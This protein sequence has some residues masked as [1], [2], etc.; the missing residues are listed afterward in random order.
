[1]KGPETRWS[2]GPPAATPDGPYYKESPLRPI[3][4]LAILAVLSVAALPAGALAGK[5][6]YGFDDNERDRLGWAIVSGDNTSMSDMSDL[7]SMGKLKSEFGRE[8]LYIRLGSDRYVVR[9]RSLMER[10]KEAMRPMQEAGRE[11]GRVARAHAERA[12][13]GSQDARERAKLARRIAKLSAKIAQREARGESAEDLERDRERIQ[14]QLDDRADDSSE[15]RASRR[16]ERE[17]D[18]RDRVASE[19][20][21]KAARRLNQE[22]R[23]ILRDAKARHLAERVD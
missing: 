12:L 5:Y 22:M 6:A 9:D 2:G 11:I 1:M 8:F 3:P 16:E 17:Q 7:D 23:D 14:D 21:E 4:A 13:E 15:E 20:M 18:A 10:A 19:R